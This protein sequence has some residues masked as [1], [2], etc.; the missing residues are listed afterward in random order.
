MK[1]KREALIC[2]SI[3]EEESDYLSSHGH[4]GILEKDK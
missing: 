4:I 1:K 2:R 3:L